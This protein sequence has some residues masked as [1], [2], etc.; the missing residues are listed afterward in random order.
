MRFDYET[1]QDDRECVAYID[2]FGH[3]IT[4][5]PNGN[6]YCFCPDGSSTDLVNW[7]PH[8]AKH[9]FYP[10]DELTITF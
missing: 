5:T 3:L 9:K 6:C 7:E 2:G 8:H 1:K 4:F 10:G